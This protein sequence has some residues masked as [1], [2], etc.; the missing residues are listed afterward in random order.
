MEKIYATVNS[1]KGESISQLQDGG[2]VIAGM[3]AGSGNYDLFVIRTNQTG[4]LLWQTTFG[5]FS[6]DRA[7]DVATNPNGAHFVTGWSWSYGQGL[8]D[9]Y[10]VKLQDAII[11][12]E[13][14]SFIAKVDGNNIVLNWSTST[15]INNL[16]FEI[17]RLIPQ[18]GIQ[19]SS[20]TL[21][22]FVSGYGTTT[23]MKS[24]SFIDNISNI[25]SI[26]HNPSLTLKYRLKQVDFTGSFKYSDTVEVEV[27]SISARF[28]LEQNYPNPFNP[29]TKIKFSIPK[30]ELVRIKVYDLLGEEIKTLVNEYRQAGTYEVEFNASDLPGGVY[31]Y[32][33]ITGSYS[34]T[35]KMILLR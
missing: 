31:F 22:G 14:T 33:I 12:V 3:S 16:G 2:F 5:G 7:F 21:V 29:V 8:G 4:D 19:N 20:W 23:E 6:D 32:R 30:S 13:L 15:E 24:Y 28:S 35:K 9:V 1:D 11:P 10:L 18:V 27:N 26:D 25:R 17:E 34:D